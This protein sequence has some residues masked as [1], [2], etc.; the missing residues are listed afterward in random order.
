[1]EELGRLMLF[2]DF[3]GPLLTRRQ[4]QA[5][6][7]HYQSDLSL[8][9]VAEQLAISRPAVADLLRRAKGQ[10]VAYEQAVGAAERLQRERRILGKVLSTLTEPGGAG[11]SSAVGL[12]EKWL[13]EE[14]VDV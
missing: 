7:L 4:Q 14:S 2:Y 9:E 3:Y 8:G 13:Q 6:E 5:F 1:M 11:V 10:L 12:L